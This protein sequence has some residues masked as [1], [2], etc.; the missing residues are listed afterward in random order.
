[1]Q[2]FKIKKKK[3]ESID[4]KDEPDEPEFKFYSYPF[5]PHSSSEE[6]GFNHINTIVTKDK[7]L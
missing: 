3:K 4:W 7:R 2:N 1:M 6:L 5:D